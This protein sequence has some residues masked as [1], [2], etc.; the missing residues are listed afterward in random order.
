MT[1]AAPSAPA[2]ALRP[3]PRP[4]C[5]APTPGACNGPVANDPAAAR[6]PNRSVRHSWP[7]SYHTDGHRRALSFRAVAFG[8]LLR[9]ARLTDARPLRDALG[10]VGGRRRADA[11]VLVARLVTPL[12]HFLAAAALLIGH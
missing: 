1:A 7:P 6:G 8:P 2:R 9:P 11:L 12:A 3:G 5:P 4:R 10:R